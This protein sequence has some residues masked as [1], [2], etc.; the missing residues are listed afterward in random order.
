MSWCVSLVSLG[1]LL[2]VCVSFL[3]PRPRVPL[4]CPE[5]HVRCASG[6]LYRCTVRF[7]AYCLSVLFGEAALSGQPLY[8]RAC[9]SVATNR[10]YLYEGLPC[11]GRNTSNAL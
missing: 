5:G 1:Q 6:Y 4:R 11:P 2:A 9:R 7:V 10:K 3:V 8:L